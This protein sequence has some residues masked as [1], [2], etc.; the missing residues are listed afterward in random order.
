MLIV[1]KV[2]EVFFVYL[3]QR[4]HFNVTGNI[5]ITGYCIHVAICYVPTVFIFGMIY[6]IF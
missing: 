6:V 5:S 4:I 1:Q 2:L 3:N